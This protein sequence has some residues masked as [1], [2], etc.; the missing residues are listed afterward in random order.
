MEQKKK[1]FAINSLRRAS[2][3]WP[4]RWMA[5]KESKIGRNQYVC[6]MCKGTF[7]KKDTALDHIIPVVDPQKGFTNFDDYID[8]LFC[9]KEG[10][11]RLCNL[12]HDKKTQEENGVRKE[13]RRKKVSKKKVSK[14]KA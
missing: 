14:K 12:C 2:Y 1:T 4:G 13:S 6:N 9:E 11:Q 3:R 8:R 10:F 7:G 5:E